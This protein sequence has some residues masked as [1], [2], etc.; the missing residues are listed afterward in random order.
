MNEVQTSKAEASTTATKFPKTHECAE[1]C[2]ECQDACLQLI[3]HCLAM[4]GEH[5]AAKHIGLLMDCVAV[6]DASH[7]LLHRGSGMHVEMCRMCAAVCEACATSC[8]ATAN[9]DET[10]LECVAA[11][12]KC[13]ELCEGLARGV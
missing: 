12:R 1:A 2:H 13:A 10:M 4:E 11:C 7:N 6:C 9:G 3:P 8:E 5:S